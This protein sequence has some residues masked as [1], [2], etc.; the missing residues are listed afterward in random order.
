MME[1]IKLMQRAIYEIMKFCFE[2]EGTQRGA[3]KQEL[4]EVYMIVSGQ[5]SASPGNTVIDVMVAMQYLTVDD[6]K[7]SNVYGLTTY[8]CNLMNAYARHYGEVLS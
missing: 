2:C 3:N 5:S 1:R 6:T 8:G 4:I 7:Q